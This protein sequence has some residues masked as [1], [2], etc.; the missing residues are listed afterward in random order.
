MREY[1]KTHKKEIREIKGVSGKRH[2]KN[3][4]KNSVKYI[5]IKIRHEFFEKI[6]NVLRYT[7]KKIK[8]KL[9]KN[10][11]DMIESIKFKFVT[12]NVSIIKNIK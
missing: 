3:K 1:Q 7:I 5:T 6:A 2:T 10:I 8:P 9:I 4:L 12:E 11:E